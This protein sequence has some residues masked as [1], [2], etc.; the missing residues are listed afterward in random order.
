[1]IFGDGDC[2][3]CYSCFVGGQGGYCSMA[4]GDEWL[5]ESACEIGVE[6]VGLV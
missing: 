6:A 3:C 5:S 2:W 4:V 1:M